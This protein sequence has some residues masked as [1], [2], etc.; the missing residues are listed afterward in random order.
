MA[1]AQV[2]LIANKL[3]RYFYFYG[4]CVRRVSLLALCG[5]VVRRRVS[6]LM[7]LSNVKINSASMSTTKL[8][9]SSC[10][11]LL[12]FRVVSCSCHK[13]SGPGVLLL[14]DIYCQGALTARL[15]AVPTIY[16][17]SGDDVIAL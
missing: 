3:G 6:M 12:W 13:R 10:L 9:R 1:Y 5:D 4:C 16:Q 14:N 7:M 17:A 8:G 11:R 15:C 2:C